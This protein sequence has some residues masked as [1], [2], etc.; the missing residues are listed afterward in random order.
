MSVTDNLFDPFAVAGRPASAVTP[1]PISLRWYQEEAVQAVIDYYAHGNTGNPI[2]ALP[3]GTGKSIVLAEIIRRVM[4]AWRDERF[5][6]STHVKELI[7]QNADKLK[8]IWPGAPLG[9]YSAGLKSAE[10]MQPIIFGGIASMYRNTSLFGW[11]GSLLVDEAHMISPGEDTMYQTFIDGL[12]KKNERLRIIGLTATWYREGHGSIAQNHIFTDIV[13]NLCTIEGF[14]RLISEGYL[15]PL[16]PRPTEYRLPLDGVKVRGGDYVE[17]QLE[18]ALNTP[19]VIDKALTEAL[20][21]GWDRGRWLVFASGV[22]HA[23]NITAWLNAHGVPAACVHSR[24]SSDEN[25]RAYAAHKSGQVRALVGM[26]K[27]TTGYDDPLIDYIIMLRPTRSTALWVQMLGRGTRPYPGKNY[28][29]VLDFARNTE[30]LGPIND[31]R[32]PKMKGA[33]GGDAPVKI[34]DECGFYNFAAARWCSCCGAEFLFETKIEQTASSAALLA[35][36]EPIVTTF[37]VVAVKYFRFKKDTKPLPSLRVMYYLQGLGKP[38][39]EFVNLEHTGYPR[40]M[41]EDWWKERTATEPPAT[42]D[43]ALL[44]SS[45]LRVPRQAK[46]WMNPPEGYPSIMSVSYD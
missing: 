34:C 13:Y 7:K 29:L 9:I 43:E 30:E 8:A 6:M 25:D 38:V 26:N 18:G 16:Y 19:E 14:A 17:S 46:V 12:R 24:K 20:R 36:T 2:I 33:G 11:R 35:G 15:C 23:E 10:Y 45:Q 39:N 28:C 44:Q 4:W 1:A 37:D 21:Y 41:A 5:I 31:P 27:F 32:I 3:T 42:I 22:D 40:R